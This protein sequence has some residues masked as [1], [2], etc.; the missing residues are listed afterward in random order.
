MHTLGSE[1]G[2]PQ[3]AAAAASVSV[4]EPQDSAEDSPTKGFL[5][6][7]ETP[8]PKYN[9]HAFLDLVD[10]LFREQKYVEAGRLWRRIGY[11]PLTQLSLERNNELLRILVKLRDRNL[12]KNQKQMEAVVVKAPAIRVEASQD[13]EDYLVRN[14][15]VIAS[16]QG[17][18]EDVPPCLLRLCRALDRELLSRLL[19]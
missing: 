6:R 12:S 9:R 14:D 11:E 16:Q 15:S 1:C 19:E 10:G 5:D 8:D 7:K 4:S 3:A 13:L 17:L 2:T 18:P